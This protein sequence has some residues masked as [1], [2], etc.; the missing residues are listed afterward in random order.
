MQAVTLFI[1]AIGSL[2][3][4][5]LKPPKAFAVLV[6]V[7]LFY[8]MFLTVQLGTLDF[9]A[10]RIVAAALLFRCLVTPGLRKRFKWNNLDKWV[11]FGMAVSLVIPL[12]A[13]K[14]PKM[15]ILERWS[16][17]IMDTFFTYLVARFCITNLSSLVS[18]IKAIAIVFV[19]LAF[20]GI[21]ECLTGWQPYIALTRF[22][23]WYEAVAQKITRVG[24]YR[25]TGA[26]GHPIRFGAGFALF[27]PLIYWLRHERGY[28]HKLAYVLTFIVM[29][30][31]LSSMSS[32]PWMMA[33]IIIGC[34]ILEHFKYLIKPLIIF[35]ISSCFLVDIISNR[36]FYDVLVRYV[37]PIGGSGWHRSRLMHLAIDHFN[38]WWLVGYG[39]LDPGWGPSLGMEWTDITNQYIVAGVRNGML[40]VIALYGVLATAIYFVVRGHR[41]AKEP[42]LRSLYWALGSTMVMVAIS[43]FGCLFSAQA[44]VLYYGILG[45]IGSSLH[46]SNSPFSSVVLRRRRPLSISE[47]AY[48]L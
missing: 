8:P 19:P 14:G 15:Q 3:V 12:I 22:C 47:E 6:A 10:S 38:E 17:G 29:L 40:G 28:W 42:A 39:G 33:I 34:L 35:M 36:R 32:G 27:I 23:P 1:S 25:A 46:L 21:A 26:F 45:I 41:A 20:L 30:G 9:K 18:A 37:N 2:F 5:I 4:L 16:G 24:L 7:L 11:V 48:G 13:I 31:V 43:M 44:G